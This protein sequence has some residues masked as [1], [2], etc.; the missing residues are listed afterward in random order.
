M[1]TKKILT[2]AVLG[3]G[4]IGLAAAAHLVARGLDPLVFEGGPTVASNVCEYGHVPLFSPW[5]YNVDEAA[6]ALL[7]AEGWAEPDPETLPTAGEL[8]ES[9]LVPLA[10]TRALASRIRLNARVQAVARAD[11]DKVKSQGR[12]QS[13]FVVRVREGSQ[14]TE[15]LV[16]AVLDTTGTWNHPNPLGANG[17]Q[18]P[19]E[20]RF[21]SQIQYDIPDPVGRHRARYAGKTVLVVGSGHS[22]ANV[23]LSLVQ[24]A[25]KEPQTCIHWAVRGE[26]LRRVF[27]GGDADGLPARGALGARLRDAVTQN[28]IALRTRFRIREL[29]QHGASLR[30]LTETTQIDDVDEIICVTGSRPDLQMTRELRLRYD[31]ALESVESL[32]ALIDPNLHSCGSVPP[33]GHREL[34]HPEPN[35]YT[36]GAKSYG[37]APTFLLMTGYEQVRSIAAALAGD[38]EAADSVHLTLPE[39]GIC[40]GAPGL[41][42]TSAG[43]SSCCSAAPVP[44]RSCC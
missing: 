3:G 29:E 1:E 19:G 28:K 31:P 20:E 25:E 18:V 10:K 21:S 5:R 26:D 38:L 9:Y 40:S 32:A 42:P 7:V 8:Y 30:V 4:P 41:E 33:H 27:G 39:T 36:A 11:F 12:E 15:T 23:L 37:R 35:F 24:L 22:A 44:A 34:S 13:A 6:R 2:V 16:D 17:L 43:V 14:T